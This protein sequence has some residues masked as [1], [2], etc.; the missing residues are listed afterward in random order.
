MR[1]REN[2][3][4]EKLCWFVGLTVKF[5]MREINPTL[6]SSKESKEEKKMLIA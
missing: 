6:T 4:R 2:C 5:L 1:E 3:G